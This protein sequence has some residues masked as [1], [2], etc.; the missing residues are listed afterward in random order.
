MMCRI[1]KDGETPAP[2]TVGIP[3]PGAK[4]DPTADSVDIDTDDRPIA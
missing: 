1:Y 3:D 4:D 2:L